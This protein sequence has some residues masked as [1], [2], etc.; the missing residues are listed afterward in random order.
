MHIFNHFFIVIII[1][2]FH[3]H[4]MFPIHL[5]GSM[6]KPCLSYGIVVCIR[7]RIDGC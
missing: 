7:H 4:H 1:L 2:Q 6:H 5:M 3:L